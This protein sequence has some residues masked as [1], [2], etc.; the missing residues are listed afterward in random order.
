M[1]R[2]SLGP[3]EGAA[4][5]VDENDKVFIFVVKSLCLVKYLQKFCKTYPNPNIEEGI[6]ML[7][8]TN[9]KILQKVRSGWIQKIFKGE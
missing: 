2:A 3:A 9:V 8:K 4:E 6:R 5:V 1:L 7:G